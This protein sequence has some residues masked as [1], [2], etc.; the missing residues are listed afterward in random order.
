MRKVLK[1]LLAGFALALALAGGAAA[2]PNEQIFRVMSTGCGPMNNGWAQSGFRT[3]VNGQV[4]LVTALHGVVGCSNVYA[5][6]EEDLGSRYVGDMTL[7]LLSIPHDVAFYASAVV[8]QMP[9]PPLSAT[10]SLQSSGLRVQGYPQ[11]SVAQLSHALS[12]HFNPARKL[13]QQFRGSPWLDRMN[14]RRSPSVETDVLLLSGAIQ[15]GYSGAPI[16]T[17]DG[18]VVG[19]ANGGLAE[20]FA[21]INW[22]I[23]FDRISWR[24]HNPADPEYQRLAGQ[25]VTM[26][27]NTP[28]AAPAGMPRVGATVSGHI[29]YNGRPV[30]ETTNA[31]ATFDFV[32]AGSWRSVP[33][34]FEYSN[35]T[36][37]YVIRNVPPGKYVPFVRLEAGYPFS[38]ESGGDFHG[39][40]SGM[41]PEIVVAPH[42]GQIRRDLS[43]IQSVHLVRPIDNQD[44]RTSLAA[45]P[46]TLYAAFYAPSA[47]SFQWDPVPGATSYQASILT[48]QSG[49]DGARLDTRSWI[50]T[51]PWFS[52][53]LAPSTPGTEYLFS[54]EARGPEGQLLG[55]F[56]NYY[57]D[58]DGGWLKFRISP[59]G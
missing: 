18:R 34:D 57:T 48:V 38:V 32:E 43:V 12:F 35:A 55:V 52:P 45:P 13:G 10:G 41:N 4:G 15:G 58:G 51:Q 3:V 31:Y 5:Q 22:A 7:V 36:G 16:L 30:A 59:S 47:E 50:L 2:Q 23:P 19:I 33:I 27:F 53:G 54:V 42:D 1:R 46:E 56:R 20:G 17:A 24:P 9:T 37:A 11:G 39:R 14:L 49:A 44:R 26:V 29:Y 8:A 25:D 28:Y 21:D 40:I 6:Q